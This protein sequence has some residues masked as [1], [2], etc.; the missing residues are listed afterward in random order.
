[1]DTR[2]LYACSSLTR[3][4]GE[5]NSADEVL[6]DIHPTGTLGR[7]YEADRISS[8][9]TSVGSHTLGRFSTDSFA[10]KCN[11]Y[12]SLTFQLSFLLDHDFIGPRNGSEHWIYR[13]SDSSS[14]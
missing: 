6:P 11:C 1:M 2:G 7:H 4:S 10:G 3:P 12:P 13:E 8:S 9:L 14:V 5:S